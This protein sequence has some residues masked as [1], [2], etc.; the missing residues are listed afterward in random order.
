MTVEG[1]PTR[2]LERHCPER[3]GEPWA[4][5]ALRPSRPSYRRRAGGGRC[6]LRLGGR[7]RLRLRADSSS[8]KA[9]SKACA[10][11]VLSID[12]RAAALALRPALRHLSSKCPHIAATPAE[13]EAAGAAGCEASSMPG[14]I[15]RS[16]LFRLRVCFKLPVAEPP[17][18]I[19]PAW[20]GHGVGAS[21][22]S[23]GRPRVQGTCVA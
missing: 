13:V 6:R 18:E 11:G 8:V 5:P 16:G 19:M 15:G 10:A 4:A 1:R 20:V 17:N 7:C 23:S 9:Q 21:A 3:L 12:M 22:R 14:A 2:P